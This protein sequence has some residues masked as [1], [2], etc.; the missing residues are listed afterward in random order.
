MLVLLLVIAILLAG[1]AYYRYRIDKW[2]AYDDEG[3]YLYAAWRISEGEVPYR[4]FLTP[5]LPVFLYPGALVLAASDY[6]VKAVRLYMSLLTLG[7]GLGLTLVLWRLW[8][9]RTALIALPLYLVQRDIFWAGRFFRPEAPMLFWGMLGL[10]LFVVAYPERKKALLGLSGVALGLSMMS[11]LFGALYVAGIGLFL[12]AEAFRTREW[13][14]FWRVSL[15]FGVP[16]A[17][18]VLSIGGHFYLKS[19]AFIADVLG[20]HLRQGRGTP[21]WMVVLKGLKLYWDL[22]KG[23]PILVTLGLVGLGISWRREPRLGRVCA[24]QVPTML[25]FLAMTRGLQERHLTYVIPFLISGAA[26]ALRQALSL[27]QK[28]SH[29]WRRLAGTVGLTVLLALMIW[30]SVRYNA[31]VASWEEHDTEQWASYLQGLTDPEDYVLSDY[32]GINFF[33]RRRTT[34]IGAGISR[35]AALSGQILGADLIREIEAYNVKVVLLNVAQGA[36]QFVNLRDYPTFKRY[37]Q[38]NFYLIDRRKRDYRLLEVYCQRDAWEG[39]TLYEVFGQ[40]LALTGIRW[41]RQQAEPGGELQLLMRWQGLAPMSEDYD[42]SLRLLDERGHV[43]GLGSKQLVDIDRETYWDEKGLERAVLIPTSRWP[44]AETTLQAFELPVMKG[45]PP[46]SY[47]VQVRV[48]PHDMWSGLM[49]LDEEGQPIGYDLPLGEATV[50]PAS[51]FPDPL[52]LAVA[53][54]SSIELASGLV[55][56]GYTLGSQPLRPGDRLTIPLLWRAQGQLTRHYELRLELRSEHRVIGVSERQPLASLGYPP[57]A[58]R[59]G[60]SLFGQPD[61]RLDLM[62]SSGS[63]ELWLVLLDGDSLIAEYPLGTLQVKG[64][65]R[66]FTLPD[67]MTQVGVRLGDTVRL[68]GYRLGRAELAAGDMLELDLVWRCLAQMEGSFTVFVHIIAEDETIL[69]QQDRLPLSGEHPTSAWLS[70]EV[71]IDPYHIPLP[72]EAPKGRYR[73]A[74]GLYDADSGARLPAYDQAGNR[75]ESDR[76]ILTSIVIH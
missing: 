4:D 62:T 9:W 12:L 63:Y 50:L 18:S 32:P 1:F 44:M 35:G 26:I 45:T 65:P 28:E 30:P 23:Q 61:L 33:A 34:P 29:L 56:E 10:Y 11:K 2:R 51:V 37:L 13:R 58:W 60:E 7:S 70:Q 72:A 39:E 40:Q 55:L 59:P 41:T 31:W 17:F 19:P 57:T 67:D 25:S 5:Q 75:L 3:G 73:I 42:V 48:H 76:I 16:F 6:A 52:E 46:G 43:W 24:W 20:H 15:S 66:Q 8:G 47:R 36:H 27:L 71:V 69:A 53:T 64:T 74:V 21:A 22:L 49:R 14:D 68:E 54:R 38:E